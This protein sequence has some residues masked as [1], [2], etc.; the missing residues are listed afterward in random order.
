MAT[1]IAIF[2]VILVIILQHTKSCT[3]Y[4]ACESQSL[5]SDKIQCSAGYACY[6]ANSLTTESSS[7]FIECAGHE[8]CHESSLISSTANVYCTGDWSCSNTKAISAGTLQCAGDQSCQDNTVNT[9][10]SKTYTVDNLLYCGGR[11]SCQSNTWKPGKKAFCD[12]LRSCDSAEII[13]GPYIYSSLITIITKNKTCT[14][15]NR[16][17]SKL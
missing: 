3:D 1:N 14:N 8:S 4:K 5:S 13:G 9:D 16:R 7:G 10:D 6:Q 15:T 2:T 12:G 11:E 17:C